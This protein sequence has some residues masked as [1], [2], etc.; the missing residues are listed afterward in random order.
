MVR[1]GSG[2]VCGSPEFTSGP[3]WVRCVV[4]SRRRC[5]RTQQSTVSA[6]VLLALSSPSTPSPPPLTP[7]TPHSSTH[8][9][10][11]SLHSQPQPRRPHSRPGPL[12]TLPRRPSP[13]TTRLRDCLGRI[14][15]TS[16]LHRFPLPTPSSRP[17]T[18]SYSTPP[19]FSTSPTPCRSPC[20]SVHIRRRQRTSRRAISS[21]SRW[22]SS[23]PRQMRRLLSSSPLLEGRAL[24]L[25][26]DSR[27]WTSTP[28]SP[29]RAKRT[30]T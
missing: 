14:P 13:A 2:P 27:A 4:S 25:P 17:L 5:S 20:T 11:C 22:P 12:T 29:S 26:P 15:V 21:M 8:T 3:V 24:A 23:C 16:Y 28:C 7:S 1:A 9:G 30:Y 18:P 6:F 19:V 10:P